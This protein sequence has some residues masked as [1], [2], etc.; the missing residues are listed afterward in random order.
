MAEHLSEL[1][2]E[3][4]GETIK[5]MLAHPF[6]TDVPMVEIPILRDDVDDLIAN[7]KGMYCINYEG[8]CLE[9]GFSKPQNDCNFAISFYSNGL[10]TLIMWKPQIEKKNDN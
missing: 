5:L 3:Q 10:I 6:D 2:N 8:I 9:M 7:A 4:A 1:T